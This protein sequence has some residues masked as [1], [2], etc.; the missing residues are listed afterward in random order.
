M[1]DFD[2]IVIG[3]GSGGLTAALA[4]AR[5][6]KR[7]IVF[8]QHYLP[9]GYSQSFRQKGFRFSPGI[10]YIGGIGPGGTLRSIYEGLGIANDLVFLELDPDGYDRVV[11]GAEHF[12]IPKGFDRFAARLTERF[13]SEARGIE[14]YF[15]I[16][17]TIGDE[18]GSLD[19]ARS[20]PQSLMRL[21][22]TLRYGLLPLRRFLDS[23]TSDP[24]LRAILTI[25]A[26]DHGLAP[27]RAPTVLHAG[28]QTYYADGGCYPRGGGHA[29]PDAFVKHIHAHGGKVSF[30]TEVIRILV[31]NGRAVGVRLANGNEVRAGIIVANSD[32]GVTWGRLVEPEHM[33]TRLRRRVRNLHY[34][35]STLSL[36]FAVDMDL[37]AAGL[38]SGNVWYSRTT[39]IDEAYE[40]AARSD[41]TTFDEIPGMFLNATTLKDP[42]MRR[43][44]L[45]TVEAIA[46]ASADAFAKWKDTVPGHRPPDYL[47]LKEYLT[48]KMFDV[49]D[50]IVPGIRDRVVFQ[51]LST[52]LTN[53]HYVGA[54]AGA[55][56]GIEHT[57]RNLGPFGFPVRSEIEGLFQCGASTF[58]PGIQGVTVSGL[59]AAAAAL[60]CERAELLNASGQSLTIL[61]AEQ[62]E[63]WPPPLRPFRV[64][65]SALVEVR[66]SGLPVVMPA[67][68]ALGTPR[69]NAQP[70]PAEA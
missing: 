56:Y 23:C 70:C 16:I 25:Q 30:G 14:R 41:L 26:G 20:W 21:P 10:H 22:T 59:A 24:L 37:R 54:T 43:D 31:E 39:D 15:R 19:S 18:L 44:G 48:G 61:P 1:Q 11:V 46:M 66:Q 63:L 58:S 34:S 42:S 12:D 8:E 2:A 17:G 51:A 67:A 28:L 49:V 5:A 40:F 36:Y 38:D 29:I 6:G 32:P 62:P 53:M 68:S 47:Q 3:S 64:P 55:M 45:H 50:K 9:G 57:L 65:A 13:P 4:M 60:G 33:S 7:V 69:R 35:V 27:S 52:P